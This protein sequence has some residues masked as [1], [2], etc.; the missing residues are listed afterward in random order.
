MSENVSI[1]LEYLKGWKA[2]AVLLLV[3]VIIVVRIVTIDDMRDNSRLVEEIKMHLLSEYYPGEI[4]KMKALLESGKNEELSESVD[5]V[6]TAKI[7]FKSIKAS[8]KIFDFSTKIKGAV[9]KV[10]YSIDDATGT[11]EKGEKYYRFEYKPLINGWR[12]IGTSSVVFYYLNF[13]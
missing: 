1:D 13:I 7:N 4:E 6:T 9:I 10:N 11:I 3:A 2:L 5:S 8:Y 12:Y